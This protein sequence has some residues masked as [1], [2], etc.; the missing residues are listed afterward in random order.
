MKTANAL[1]NLYP[2]PAFSLGVFRNG[3][4]IDGD[5]FE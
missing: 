3:F 1:D 4:A 5:V 2:N